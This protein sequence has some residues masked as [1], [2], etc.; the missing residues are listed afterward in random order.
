MD[1]SILLG[2]RYKGFLRDNSLTWTCLST[3]LQQAHQQI[4]G[5]VGTHGGTRH[6]DN[7]SLRAL[8]SHRDLFTPT[9]EKPV[10]LDLGFGAGKQVIYAAH[11][12]WQAYGVDISSECLAAAQAMI[13]NAIQGGYIPEGLAKVVQGD[14]FPRDFNR[15]GRSLDEILVTFAKHLSP[16]YLK[17]LQ[18]S[19]F[20]LVFKRE[21][22]EMKRTAPSSD[23]YAELGISL[24]EV[25]VF[26][27]YQVERHDR[28]VRLF[29]ERA[30]RGAFLLFN[31]SLNDKSKEYD[32]VKVVEEAGTDRGE[33]YILVL[34][35]KVADKSTRNG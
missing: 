26:Y 3:I 16:K 35:Q 12:G 1:N 21:I 9:A 20:E 24:D 6:G 17:R 34:Y 30:K 18:R 13:S 5:L 25:D 11:E 4:G 27:H 2:D 8:L 19:G 15:F 22:K 23:P 14:F 33:G 29:S 7:S 32:N 10:F 31:R 28:I